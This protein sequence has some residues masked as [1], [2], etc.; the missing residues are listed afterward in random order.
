MGGCASKDSKTVEEDDGAGIEGCVSSSMVFLARYS[1]G[2]WSRAAPHSALTSQPIVFDNSVLNR[3]NFHMKNVQMAKFSVPKPSMKF[4]W[5]NEFLWKIL[6]FGLL[7]PKICQNLKWNGRWCTF[8][9]R[10]THLFLFLLIFVAT[11]S[12]ERGRAPRLVLSVDIL[13]QCLCSKCLL[14]AW[15]CLF[16]IVSCVFYVVG[17]EVSEGKIKAER[18]REKQ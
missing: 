8:S 11:M 14:I 16:C 15:N 18:V 12:I 5:H 2:L 13:S 3:H 17:K 4:T 7:H 10:E 6:K 9:K 1:S